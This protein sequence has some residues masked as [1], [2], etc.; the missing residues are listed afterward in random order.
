[1]HSPRMIFVELQQVPQDANVPRASVGNVPSV[2]QVRVWPES[3]SG[4]R[5]VDWVWIST[6]V[7]LGDVDAVHGGIGHDGHS[8]VGRAAGPRVGD[9]HLLALVVEAQYDF[10]ERQVALPVVVVPLGISAVPACMCVCVCVCLCVCVCVRV[11]MRVCKGWLVNAK[12]TDGS[13]GWD[14]NT[15]AHTHTHTQVRRGTLT[16]Q[17]WGRLLRRGR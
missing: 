8:A 2:D 12:K 7:C 11:C 3:Q 17:V 14:T 9:V 15:Q 10:G 16:P 5:W 6:A 1:M 4:I 13:R